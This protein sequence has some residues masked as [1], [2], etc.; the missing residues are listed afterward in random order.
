MQTGYG[1]KYCTPFI[2]GKHK[3]VDK[4][5]DED[6]QQHKA[7][8]QMEWFLKE[9]ESLSEKSPV[10]HDY[11]QILSGSAVRTS[12]TIY[13]TTTFPP[14]ARAPKGLVSVQELCTVTWN[15]T[16]NA[17]KLPK[18]TNRQG[19]TFS[20]LNYRIQMECEDGTV[21]FKIIHKGARVG[22]Q[23]FEV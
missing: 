22:E 16:I 17:R 6:E 9:G 21:N 15:K 4:Y 2:V 3:K 14:P 13:C 7:G 5:W 12:D 19:Q 8:N 18:W 11:Y 10:H 20:K 23:N 1:V